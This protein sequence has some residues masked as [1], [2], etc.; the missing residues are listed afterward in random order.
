MVDVFVSY[1]SQDRERVR[2]LVRDIEASGCSV[3]WDREI[4]AGTA[5]DREIEQVLDKARCVVVAWSKTSIDSPWV[6]TEANEG[7]KRGILIPVLL[8]PVRPPLAF[9]MLQTI[10]LA[11]A[12][13]TATMMAA[14]EKLREAVE[15]PPFVG[16]ARELERVERALTSTT[17]GEGS[18]LLFSGEGGI[19]KTRMTLEAERLARAEDIL[20][21][22][23]HCQ[24]DD[25]P[26]PYQPLLEQIERLGRLVGPQ[27][28]RERL[29]ENAT[30][31]ARLMPEL[32]Q[33]YSDIP[34]YPTLPP[35]QE[36]RYLLHGVCEFVARGAAIQPLLLVFEDLHWADESTCI[37]L[38][39]LAERLRTE[40]VLIVGTYRDEGLAPG[41]PFAKVRQDLIRER[42][43]EDLHLKRLTHDEI[44][45]LLQRQFSAEPPKLLVELI[46]SESEGN[47]F[48]IEE[49]IAHL[50]ESGRLLTPEGAL[51][52]DIEIGDTDVARGVRMI[53]DERLAR[54]S[55]PCQDVLTVAAV[56]GRS[57]AFD[58]LAKAETRHDEDAVLDAIEEAERMRLI[59]DISKDRTARYRFVHEQIRQALLARLSLPR[60]QRLHLRVGEA[61]E[62]LHGNEIA[63]FAG[64]IGHHLYHAGSA[65]DPTRTAE[66]LAGGGTR[67]MAAL[68]F[69]DALRQFELAIAVLG[70]RDSGTL[71]RLH[72]LRADALRGAERIPEA[73]DALTLAVSVASEQNQKDDLV[74]TRCRLLLDVWRGGEALAD[75]ERLEARATEAGD[76]GRLLDVLPV[77]SRA[78]YVMSLDHEGFAQKAREAYERTIELARSEGARAI[79]ARSLLATV[80]FVDYWP[81]FVAQ[82]QA[83]LAEAEAIAGELGDEELQLDVAARSG[84]LDG[85]VVDSEEIRRRLL[86]RRDP[87]RLNAHYFVMM[88]RC[89]HLGQPE[90]G[91]EIADEAIALAQRIGALPVQYPTIK[92]FC[93]LELGRLGEAW[94]SFGQEVVSTPFGAAH[95]SLGQLQFEIDIG[96]FDAAFAR[97]PRLIAACHT[98]VRDWM[99]NWIASTWAGS[100]RYFHGN[101]EVLSRI[102]GLISETGRSLGTNG[103]A[104]L[105][106]AR[107]DLGAARAALAEALPERRTSFQTSAAT[108]LEL[109]AEVEAAA[110][111]QA[112]RASLEKAAE[113]AKRRASNNSL[114]KIL[115]RRAAI[116]ARL[117][118]ETAPA[119]RAE[120]VAL[121]G[122]LASSL[123]D[124]RQRQIL[125]TGRVSQTVGLV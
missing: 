5:F 6:R 13:A 108:R 45:T 85:K 111:L 59:E 124:E 116:E 41:S 120:A 103:R 69:E 11:E 58:L 87:I 27:A 56:A 25:A 110:D 62:A 74:L 106:L 102:E 54:A 1:S 100:A 112:A 61:L 66:R 76:A 64:E 38:R 117:G 80:H 91:V 23:G 53:V 119:T 65:A 79:L 47:P 97:S 70:D 86:A 68:A 9:R 10:D 4:G 51:R 15:G 43:V 37:L 46:V 40:R 29:G 121:R 113:E 14:I 92:G 67:A 90:R 84:R 49:L 75:L 31:L 60:R 35:E 20:V 122:A 17:A 36:R 105:A 7:L 81:E 104:A 26:A 21:L 32:Q 95:Q 28:L 101:A 30:E 2:G 93:L 63:K 50:K 72:G 98:L 125:L 123:S 19:G 44:A 114:W 3:W 73:L 55:V 88:W 48:F 94:T 71:A 107:G 109:L 42:L 52:T 39:H 22:R 24:D 16:R 82:A 99:L 78:Y 8:E 89:L 115:A 83:N 34:P 77:L 18:V 118:L 57:F 96:D 33:R 12:N